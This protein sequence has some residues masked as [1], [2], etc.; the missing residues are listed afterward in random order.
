ME[1]VYRDYSKKGVKFYYI[2][3][4]LAHPGREGL[5]QPF[6]IEERLAHVKAAKKQL[7]TEM[8]W[9]ADSMKNE[10][11]HA[12]GNRNNSEFVIDPEGNIVHAR[13]WS[14]P[15]QLRKDLAT[16]VGDVEEPTT[17][18]DL[19][20]KHPGPPKREAATGVVARV[21]ALDGGLPLKLKPEVD[22]ENKMPFYAKLRAEAERSVISG[23]S[24]KIH[25]GFHLDP[26]Y[27]VHWNNLADPLAFELKAGSGEITPSSG[28]APKIQV[29]SDADPREFLLEVKDL[30]TDKPLTL[31]VKY[32]ACH[33]KE[34]WCKP[35]T[36]SYLITLEHDRDAGRVTGSRGNRGRGR[37]GNRAGAG[38]GRDPGRMQ[39]M[40]A[41]SDTNKDGKV[42]RDEFRGP[43]RLFERL[44]S[45]QNGEISKE[46][47]ARRFERG[48]QPRRSRRPEDSSRP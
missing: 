23:G 24:G 39:Q 21:P 43:D 9:V 42:S 36:Q 8:P 16:L 20:L 11:K 17:I 13:S 3:K 41:D 1:T 31:T 45:D 2:Y 18:A 35:V 44:D 34:G 29:K 12:L 22:K 47:I 4:T 40:L 37:Q 38:P 28:M 30:K 6:E 48:T 25:L 14:D 33:E 7:E 26:I 5:V 46:E 19:K 10:L 32:I 27:E 15:A